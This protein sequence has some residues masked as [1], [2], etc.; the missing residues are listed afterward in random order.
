LA[1]AIAAMHDDIEPPI[2][3]KLK[4]ITVDGPDCHKNLDSK[5]GG[6]ASKALRP[7]APVTR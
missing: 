7:N 3:R 5:S 1:L 4:Q 2:E 6:F